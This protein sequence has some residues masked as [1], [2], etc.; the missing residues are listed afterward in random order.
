MEFQEQLSQIEILS[1]PVPFGRNCFN[2][3]APHWHLVQRIILSLMA[4]LR[5]WINA[6]R[7]IWGAI[8]AADQKNG[9]T[10]YL[11]QSGAIIALLLQLSCPHLKH[12]MVILLV[13]FLLI[14]QVLQLMQQLISSW[15]QEI[16]FWLFWKRICRRLSLG[17]SYLLTRRELRDHLKWA[18]G[19]SYD[20]N[21]TDKSHWQWGTI[22]N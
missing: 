20:C 7:A 1:S 11:W 3:M 5:S 22:W 4:R 18:I 2:Y 14:S 8:L 12:S 9:V 19:C 21:P 10:G 15:S 17:W 13:D 16:R 6:W